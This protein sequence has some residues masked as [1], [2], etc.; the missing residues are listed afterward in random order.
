MLLI[1]IR[2][3][4]KLLVFNAICIVLT[5]FPVMAQFPVSASPS[6][7]QTAWK[8]AS[9]NVRA[10]YQKRGIAKDIAQWTQSEGIDILC[11]QEMRRSVAN[12][13]AAHYPYRVYAPNNKRI[14]TAIYSKFPII[15]HG[16]LLF[17]AIEENSYAK[18]SAGYADIILPYDTIRFINIHLSSTGIKDMDL[19]IEPSREEWIEK[20]QFMA[21]KIARSDRVRA[22][23]GLSILQWVDES[24][25]PVVLTGDFNSVPG[26]NIYARLLWKLD[27]PYLFKGSGAWGSYLP[28]LQ[29]GFPL[30]IDWTLV[31]EKLPYSGQYLS[32]VAFSDHRPLIT[33]FSAR[34]EP[35]ED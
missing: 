10:F 27:D 3:Q 25:Y 15:K 14:G 8:V 21:K 7:E 6:P 18:H 32:D 17:D 12:P 24:P 19:E 29:K 4:S 31:D 23:Q 5:F 22:K 2:Y 28:L 33:T 34:I 11:T 13:V 1:A 35:Q 20:G 26:G 16:S 9:Y 30:R